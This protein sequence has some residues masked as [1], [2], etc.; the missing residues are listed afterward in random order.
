LVLA[1]QAGA[2]AAPSTPLLELQARASAGREALP[3]SI[4]RLR[5]PG[6]YP[7]A[8]SPGLAALAAS[9]AQSTGG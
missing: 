4:R 8:L 2:R 7:V 6:P 3:A 1:I 9:L 5:D